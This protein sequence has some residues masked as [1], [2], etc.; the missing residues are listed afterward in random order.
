MRIVLVQLYSAACGKNM[1][2][3]RRTLKGIAA[4]ARKHRAASRI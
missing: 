1:S 3:Y 2:Q 4:V